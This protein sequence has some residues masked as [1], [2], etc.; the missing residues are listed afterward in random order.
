MRGAERST[1]RRPRV[2]S[3]AAVAIAIA[4]A[5]AIA[6]CSGKQAVEPVDTNG[7]VWT[8]ITSP[9]SVVNPL[10]PDWR[11][12]SLL[13]QGFN[14]ATSSNRAVKLHGDGSQ[15]IYLPGSGGPSFSSDDRPKWA[16]D[17]IIVYCS[18]FSTAYDLYSRSLVTG[19][20]HRITGFVGGE[21]DPD[22]IPGQPGLVYT[23][24]S[25]RFSG[26]ITIIPDTAATSLDVRYLTPDT[27]K[28]GEPDWD[29]TGQRVCFSA[30]GA[31]GTRH[32]WIATL[33]P[34]DT[35][36]TQITTGPSHDLTPRWT[37]DGQR[38]IFVSDRTG[39]GGVWWVSASGEDAGLDVIAFAD[40][41]RSVYT[42]AISSDGTR[43][44]VTSD[45]LGIG[46]C[47]WVLT[48]FHF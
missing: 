27:L 9:A 5:G 39:R 17:S 22:P 26:R 15:A 34:G 11:G 28:A 2:A 31:E 21:F 6:G 10:G 45:E 18:G 41:G 20:V 19:V 48:N 33:S 38:I 23:T 24:G 30:E 46:V 3:S 29:P 14:Q 35:T 43:I 42:P 40:T 32:V 7:V 44:V 12:D 37:P 25:T 4:I 8:R 1:R 47:L 36:L 13:V 16:S